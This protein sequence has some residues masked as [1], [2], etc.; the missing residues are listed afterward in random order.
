MALPTVTDLTE[1]RPDACA[2]TAI[3]TNPLQQVKDRL[4]IEWCNT[5]LDSD[6]AETMMISSVTMSTLGADELFGQEISVVG[7]MVRT[8]TVT[9]A[10][11]G[12]T[13][14]LPCTL[15]LLEDG[16]VCSFV[17]K[18]VLESLSVLT[19]RRLRGRWDPPLCVSLRQVKLANGH[20]KYVL[21]RTSPVAPPT[22]KKGDK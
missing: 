18:G 22:K 3:Q 20:R 4:R 11:S 6:D 21:V 10:E 8:V 17:S 9:D 1:S 14:D 16:R 15:L 13:Q 2:L 7:C 19:A 5:P 12:Q